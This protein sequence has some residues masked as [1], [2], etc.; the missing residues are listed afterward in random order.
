M[1]RMFCTLKEAAAWL[2]TSESEVR[3]MLDRGVVTEFRNGNSRL[4]RISDVRDLVRGRSANGCSY[5][6]SESDPAGDRLPDETPQEALSPEV[7]L[8]RTGVALL[9]PPV[10]LIEPLADWD[11]TTPFSAGPQEPKLA[12]RNAD[13]CNE[14]QTLD[15]K[16]QWEP[17][18][19]REPSPEQPAARHRLWMGIID[20]RPLAILGISALAI[21]IASAI[22]SATYVL[23]R[24][25]Q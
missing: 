18:P 5:G 22:A 12:E 1:A 3:T 7:K 21:A 8:P 23:V 16:I 11:A 19:W 2:N 20:D 13:Y 9:E 24:F 6:Q 4:L 10:D 25:L 14:K 17:D 15:T